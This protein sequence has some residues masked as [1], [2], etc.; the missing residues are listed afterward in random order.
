MA[1]FDKREIVA[2]LIPGAVLALWALGGGFLFA[3]TLEPDERAALGAMLEPRAAL[4]L[5][6]WLLLSGVLGALS[7]QVYLRW[8]A[9]AARLA[10]EAQVLLA[11]DTQRT[12]APQGSAETGALAGVI[13]QFAHQRDALRADI[14]AQVKEASRGVEQ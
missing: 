1:K 3:A 7:R 6:G 11:T 5:L 14:T 9:S 2:T 13:N 4:L 10:E 8:V 12:L